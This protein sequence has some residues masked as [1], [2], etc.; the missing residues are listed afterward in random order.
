MAVY[1]F[2]V[3]IEDNHEIYRDIE[4]L[5]RHDFA[6]LHA[7]VVKAF[8]FQ[9]GQPVEYMASDSSWYGGETIVSLDGDLK[10]DPARIVSHVND[11]HQRF[12]CV[13]VSHKPV[14]LALEL[15]KI[16]KD[17]EDTE[18]PR[19]VKVHGDAPFYT[20]PPVKPMTIT[21]EDRVEEEEVKSKKRKSRSDDD[22]EPTD[23]QL[24]EE[25]TDLLSDDT[26]TSGEGADDED[27]ESDPD[28]DDE[29]DDDDET[30]FSNFDADEL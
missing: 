2:R 15:L 18:Y 5:G 1:R 28:S 29:E 4:V 22:D 17:A 26:E 3:F 16:I 14:E 13:T 21:D 20:Q 6:V 9:I 23:D 30:R 7:A 27:V 25:D 24:A 10:G 8:G 11:P 19:C 12:L